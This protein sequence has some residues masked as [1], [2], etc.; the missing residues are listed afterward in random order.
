MEAVLCKKGGSSAS[1]S[2]DYGQLPLTV[3]QDCSIKNRA[4]AVNNFI[5]DFDSTRLLSSLRRNCSL[6]VNRSMNSES[7]PVGNAGRFFGNVDISAN[8]LN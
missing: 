8:L 1:V 5:N 2:E 3:K 7:T 6:W 4:I